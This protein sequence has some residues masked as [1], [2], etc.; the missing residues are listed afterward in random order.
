MRFLQICRIFGF[1]DFLCHMFQVN[2]IFYLKYIKPFK[3]YQ[4][5]LWALLYIVRTQRFRGQYFKYLAQCAVL[6]EDVNL[7]DDGRIILDGAVVETTEI[8]D[9]EILIIYVEPECSLYVYSDP[10]ITARVQHSTYNRTTNFEIKWRDFN[11][12]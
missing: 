2:T 7:A 5:C 12:I 6:Y 3:Y 8:F 11:F 4:S 9:H 1:L 10:I